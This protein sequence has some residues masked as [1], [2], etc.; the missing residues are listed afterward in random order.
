MSCGKQSALSQTVQ[1]ETALQLG[2]TVV[3]CYQY[4]SDLSNDNRK[5]YLITDDG[6]ATLDDII[7]TLEQFSREIS[8][9]KLTITGHL[10][11][12]EL[13]VIVGDCKKECDS[14]RSSIQTWLQ[15]ASRTSLELATYT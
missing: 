2:T 15:S 7:Q 10:L 14:L 13:G 4:I 6:L 9:T 11:T 5:I 12:R 1:V 8:A 3:R